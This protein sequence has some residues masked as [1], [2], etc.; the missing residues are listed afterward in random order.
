MKDVLSRKFGKVALNAIVATYMF[1]HTELPTWKE[2][3]TFHD[4]LTKVLDSEPYLWYSQPE[5]CEAT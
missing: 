5:V 4:G 2:K 3:A 1:L